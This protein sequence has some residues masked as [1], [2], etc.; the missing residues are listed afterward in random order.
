VDLGQPLL[1][2]APNATRRQRKNGRAMRRIS[3]VRSVGLIAAATA[4]ALAGTACSSSSSTGNGGQPVKAAAPVGAPDALKGIC[5]AKVVIQTNWWPQ[6]EYGAVY[7]LLGEKPDIDKAKKKVTGTLVDNG[8]D[9]GV[10]L[11]VRSGGPANNFTPSASLLYTDNGITLGGVDLD[12]AAQLSADKPAL[13]VFAPLDLSPLVLLWDPTQYP[14][15][16]TISDI[17]QTETKVLYFQGSTYMSYLTGSGILRQTQI[18][19]SYDGT[20]SQFV[21]SGGKIVQQGFLTNEVYGYEHEVEHWKKP[22]AWQLVSDS[23]Y[24][25]YPETL[26]IRPDRKAELTPCLTKLVPIL[27]RATVAYLNDP[28]TTNTLIVQLVKDYNAF[29]YSPE[30]AAYAVK[31]MKENGVLGNGSNR[32]VGDFDMSRVQR[33]INIV[34]P[35]FAGQ[36]KK[37]KEGLK[38]EDLVTN[39][40]IDTSIGV[41]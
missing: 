1:T 19:P 8:V 13:S 26:A 12:Q 36:K 16:N 21:A 38:P 6:A 34:K 15:F 3:S 2:A 28:D 39:E 11:E 40:F 41:K 29:P 31:A 7:R 17:G 20:P 27:Q 14:Q 24:P 18:D 5:P 4:L 35:I 30:R 9:T 37:L 33:V 23:G 10:Q 32:T 22:V 25:I